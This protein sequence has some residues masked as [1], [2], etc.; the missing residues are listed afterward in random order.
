MIEHA[1][2]AEKLAQAEGLLQRLDPRVKV[3]G[4]LSLISAAILTQR[5]P[6]ILGLFM[7]AVALA[8][9]SHLPIRIL[10]SGVWTSVLL[11][12]GGIA[13]PAVF[14]VPGEV[15]Y[16]LP[17]LNWP[18][19]AQGLESAAFLV[20]RAETTATFAVLLIFCTPWTHVLKALRVLGVPAVLVTIL[21]M[22]YRYIFLLLQTAHA[23]FEARQ[24]R[25][26]GT[27]TGTERRRLIVASAGVLLSKSV[28]LANEVFL[29]MQSRGYRGEH[30]TLD[31]FQMQARDWAAVVVIVALA[32]S[33]LWFGS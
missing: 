20:S 21:G 29:A 31:E 1:L 13:L 19:T 7:T 8:C 26:L 11:F 10:V 24:S 22:T 12:T 2:Y 9:L 33:A 5:L 4:M 15:L 27:L 14:L 32:A 23:M 17:L 25:L 30:L 6:V 3:L 18:L 28:Y 16:R